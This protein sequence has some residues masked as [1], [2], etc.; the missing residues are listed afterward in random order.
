MRKSMKFC[1]FTLYFSLQQLR[2]LIWISE[3]ISLLIQTFLPQTAHSLAFL[4]DKIEEASWLDLFFY[5]LV[6]HNLFAV[7]CFKNIDGS[8]DQ[9]L[10]ENNVV[11]FLMW[12]GSWA[13]T[14]N[15]VFPDR[16]SKVYRASES[17]PCCFHPYQC[18]RRW[19]KQAGAGLCQAQPSLSLDL[20]NN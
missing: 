2:L 17:A 6:K 12:S 10:T 4:S 15:S 1:S 11:F 19:Q 3:C 18:G 9:I 7:R 13:R 14:R 8:S 5:Y 16:S 20:D